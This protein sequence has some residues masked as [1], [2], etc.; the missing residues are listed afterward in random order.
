MVMS[1]ALTT[2][3]R[4]NRINDQNEDVTIPNS[5]YYAH[6]FFCFIIDAGSFSK[7]TRGIFPKSNKSIVFL[8]HF[9]CL[10]DIQIHH[11]VAQNKGQ[12]Q[13]KA[14]PFVVA[15][16]SVCSTYDRRCVGVGGQ[17]GNGELLG[18]G[19]T[20]VKTATTCFGYLTLRNP[21]VLL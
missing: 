16:F 17:H 12:L 6:C 2:S 7:W 19:R 10:L 5:G 14:I 3:N 1:A 4:S 21:C 18:D 15:E 8:F 9:A 11:K 13:S 20:I